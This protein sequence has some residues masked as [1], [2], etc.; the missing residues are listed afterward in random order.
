MHKNWLGAL[1]LAAL[2]SLGGPLVTRAAQK[3]V[4]LQVERLRQVVGPVTGPEVVL[5]NRADRVDPGRTGDEVFV[6]EQ[7]PGRR[8]N[9]DHEARAAGAEPERGS[10]PALLVL[11]AR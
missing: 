3:L 6:G 4:L 11:H 8:V 7:H 10:D 5:P 1:T 9:D 2:A